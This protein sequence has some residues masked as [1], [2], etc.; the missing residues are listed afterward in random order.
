MILLSSSAAA[1]QTISPL[2][3]IA[4]VAVLQKTKEYNLKKTKPNHKSMSK[5]QRDT[6]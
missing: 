2:S 6:R 1:H 3:S 4:A 5:G